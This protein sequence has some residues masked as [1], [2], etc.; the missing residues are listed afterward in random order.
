MIVL[1]QPILFPRTRM[2]VTS[3]QPTAICFCRSPLNNNKLRNER[4]EDGDLRDIQIYSRVMYEGFAPQAAS[5]DRPSRTVDN[6]CN[7]VKTSLS[8]FPIIYCVVPSRIDDI[9]L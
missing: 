5:N 4:S 3:P 7:H 1:E 8:F 6:A 9:E 2:S